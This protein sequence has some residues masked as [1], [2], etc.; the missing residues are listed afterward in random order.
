MRYHGPKDR[1][2]AA[3]S[4]ETPAADLSELAGSEYV[5]VQ[6]AVA[7]NPNTPTAAL[8]Q[9]FPDAIRDD[10]AW[11]ILLGLLRNPKLS[12]HLSADILALLMTVISSITPRDYYATEVVEALARSSVVP[13]EVVVQLADAALVPRHLRGRIAVA[14]SSVPLLGKLS[15]DPSEKVRT[16]A[17]NALKTIEQDAA[18]DAKRPRRRA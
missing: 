10:N 5:F 16:R 9:L 4:E 12:G 17:I 11:Q 6:A 2:D 13:E 3:R 14:E 8:V 18:A 1:V 15:D 7:E